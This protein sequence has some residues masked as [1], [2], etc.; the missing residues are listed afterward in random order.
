MIIYVSEL[1]EEGELREI[2]KETGCGLETIRFGIAENLDSLNDTIAEVKRT[3]RLF[4]NPPLTVH[5]PF[6]DINPASFDSH[7][8][9]LTLRRFHEAYT[10]AVETGAEKI[11]FHS[12]MIPN[13]YFSQGWAEHTAAFWDE[14]LESHSDIPVC[15]ENVLDR[16]IE[17][18]LD[19]V[20]LVGKRHENFGICLDLGH[21]Q[22]YSA[23]PPEKWMG[24][25]APYIFHIHV[26]DNHGSTQNDNC[27]DD[28]HLAF[29]DG[30][31]NITEIF[32]R[33]KELPRDVSFTVECNKKEDVYKSIERIRRGIKNTNKILTP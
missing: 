27:R 19:L 12:G 4:G 6:L 18:L 5:G 10:G 26:H 28:Q 29:G 33:I 11:I 15:V 21:A 3:L 14:F 24:S 9:K 25:L 8:R 22:C 17:P 20:R 13:V 30:I 32:K 16:E 2:I 1:L 23:Y 31:M 7:A